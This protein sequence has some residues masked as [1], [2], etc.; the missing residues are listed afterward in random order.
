[1]TFQRQVVLESSRRDNAFPECRVF[2]GILQNQSL[3]DLEVTTYHPLVL[4]LPLY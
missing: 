1:V 3:C 4:I 2:H